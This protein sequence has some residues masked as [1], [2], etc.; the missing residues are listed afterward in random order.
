M[1][2]TTARLKLFTSLAWLLPV[3]CSLAIEW[4]RTLPDDRDDVPAL[5]VGLVSDV[6]SSIVKGGAGVSGD[7]LG[8]GESGLG[9][10]FSDEYWGWICSMR[11]EFL[12]TSLSEQE[13]AQNDLYLKTSD[14]VDFN[15]ASYQY[16][17]VPAGAP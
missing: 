6:Q 9:I 7:D 1:T 3:T 4:G 16:M 12:L 5:T 13:T 14:K 17:R 2:L 11:V 15:G 8:I 10:G